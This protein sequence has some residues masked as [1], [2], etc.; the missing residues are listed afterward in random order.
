MARDRMIGTPTVIQTHARPNAGTKDA[1]P[2]DA[3]SDNLSDTHNQQDP[4][5]ADEGR[6]QVFHPSPVMTSAQVPICL[7]TPRSHDGSG[8]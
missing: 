7:A 4:C 6:W 8:L 2:C 1:Q 3:M 5:L